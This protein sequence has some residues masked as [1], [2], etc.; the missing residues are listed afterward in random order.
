[1]GYFS[2]KT[3][4]LQVQGILANSFPIYNWTF[5][6]SK[7]VIDISNTNAYGNELY[8]ANLFGGNVTAEGYLDDL[9]LPE[10]ES[11]E[12]TYANMELYFDFDS[13]PKIGFFGVNAIQVLI[14][15]IDY[16]VDING[17][18][19]FTINTVVSPEPS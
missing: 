11:L 9:S 5:T 4:S 6:K 15:S 2:G 12:G 14:E 13:D 3:G 17:A 1:M 18:T 19:K 10:L 8:I 7:S 16:N